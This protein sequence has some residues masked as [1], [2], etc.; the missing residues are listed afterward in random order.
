[1]YEYIVGVDAGGTKT[2]AR[3]YDRTGEEL[4]NANEGVGNMLVDRAAALANV[5]KAV[6]SCLERV[7]THKETAVFVGAAGVMAGTNRQDMRLFLRESF[8]HCVIEVE[9]DGCLA[10]YAKLRGGDGILVVSGTGSIAYG[11]L[12]G[13]LERAG[14]WGHLLE[15]EGSGYAIAVGA[16]ARIM[17]ETDHSIPYSA[18]ST[19]LLRHLGAD[20]FGVVNF[21]Y[22]H[23]KSEIASLT[24]LVVA[25]ADDGDEK[26]AGLL[27]VAGRRLAELAE[28]VYRKT[29]FC[30]VA[31][32]V[33]SG[34]VLENIP[35]VRSTFEAA[36]DVSRFLPVRESSP[37][38]M[39]AY[40]YFERSPCRHES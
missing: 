34:G 31:P 20:V 18:C 33:V 3:L 11:K 10:I 21:V 14:G 25:A 30:G 40:Y 38:A 37:A 17:R 6:S 35:L 7:P 12:G 13:K 29:G 19:S 15:E 32:I 5:R 9:T 28:T 27:R 23:T 1:M 36:L 26:A 22:N 39:G 8:P 4:F 2:N 16:L 24:K